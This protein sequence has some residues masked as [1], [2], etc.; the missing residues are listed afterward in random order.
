M[1]LQGSKYLFME[2]FVQTSVPIIRDGGGTN[3]S[4]CHIPLGL[5]FSLADNIFIKKKNVK[6]PN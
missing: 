2:A 1:Y 5:G 4:I 6:Y 3:T